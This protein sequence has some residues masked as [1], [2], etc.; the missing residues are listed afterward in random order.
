MFSEVLCATVE[1]AI[2]DFFPFGD[3]VSD[4]WLLLTLPME[5]RDNFNCSKEAYDAMW[6]VLACGTAVDAIPEFSLLL[7]ISAGILLVVV[8]GPIS[9]VTGWYKEELTDV[10]SCIGQCLRWVDYLRSERFGMLG[11]GR[12]SKYSHQNHAD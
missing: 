7:A 3:L 2:G 8:L 12:R 4:I 5:K 10:I 6:W 11:L 1:W 9:L